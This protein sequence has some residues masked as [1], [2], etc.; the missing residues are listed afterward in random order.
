MI[1]KEIH[2]TSAF[3]FLRIAHDFK[4][5]RNHTSEIEF[6]RGHS[7]K[8]W[9]LVPSICRKPILSF[10]E[11]LINEFI[12]RRPDEFPESD[13]LFNILAKMQH[14]GL[15]TRLLDVES[16]DGSK[17]HFVR[18]TIFLSMSNK[19]AIWRTDKLDFLFSVLIISRRK[20]SFCRF[21]SSLILMIL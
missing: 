16:G 20:S 21:F 12:R 19:L 18:W 4:E 5:S 15:H 14:Y 13:E 17:T 6:Y 9:R 3:D 11:E 7:D 10:E 2:I 1:L 8:E